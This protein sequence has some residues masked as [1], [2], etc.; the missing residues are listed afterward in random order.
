[1]PFHFRCV[2]FRNL[3]VDLKIDYLLEVRYCTDWLEN[4]IIF[5][6]NTTELNVVIQIFQRFVALFVHIEEDIRSENNKKG[7][8]DLARYLHKDPNTLPEKWYWMFTASPQKKLISV[9]KLLFTKYELI[10][11][12][13]VLTE[14][15]LDLSKY[16]YDHLSR[17][18][19]K[20]IY[21]IKNIKS[22]LFE[23]AKHV[24]VIIYEI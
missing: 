17:E 7:Y 12:P 20:L 22:I 4:K 6:L 11:E 10:H 3:L 23:K 15:L 8:L 24:Q 2:A 21:T 16:K 5:I 13:E 1:M 19:L 14:K 18:S 9:M